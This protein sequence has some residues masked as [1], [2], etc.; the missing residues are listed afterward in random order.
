MTPLKYPYSLSEASPYGS[1]RQLECWSDADPGSER[2]ARFVVEA[3]ITQ[4]TQERAVFPL[5]PYLR[6]ATK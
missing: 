1:L 4:R 5:K 3:E 6:V 2:L